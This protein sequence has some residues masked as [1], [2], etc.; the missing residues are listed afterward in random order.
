MNIHE[1]KTLMGQSIRDAHPF[2]TYRKP[3]TD[4]LVTWICDSAEFVTHSDMSEPGFVFSPFDPGLDSVFFPV[5]TSQII[6]TPMELSS[7]N[8]SAVSKDSND[9]AVDRKDK[10]S[11][12]NLVKKAVEEIRSGKA[13]KIVVSRKE[14]ILDIPVNPIE[15]FVRLAALYPKAFSYMWYHP[16][17]G[18]WAGS[19]PE[20]LVEVEDRAFVTMSLAGTQRYL[21]NDDVTWGGKELE[22]QRIVTDLIQKELGSLLESIGEPYTQ[23]AGHLLH[24][25]TDLRGSLKKDHELSD[26]IRRL[27][28]TAAICG[29]PRKEALEFIQLNEGYSREYYTGFLGEVNFP[30]SGSAH[31][32]VNLRCMRMFPEEKKAWVYVG[33]G[34]TASSE[35]EKEW[36]ET[37]A[38]SETMKRVFS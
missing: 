6:R 2:V 19:T 34:I 1:L 37:R 24:L 16:E 25:R 26:L 23:R 33:G 10:D 3:G 29:L 35:P 30:V 12:V 31:L 28:P 8:S 32:F 38:K 21:G 17:V 20:T 9:R 7:W 11:H 13:E 18:L 22:E 4:S 14:E 15:V 36:E 5:R 27:H